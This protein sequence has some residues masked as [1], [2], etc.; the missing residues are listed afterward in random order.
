MFVIFSA[1]P[2]RNATQKAVAVVATAVVAWRAVP[3]KR[4]AWI[5][6]GLRRW[7]LQRGWPDGWRLTRSIRGRVVRA[8]VIKIEKVESGDRRQ[9]RVRD[10][11]SRM[12]CPGNFA[13]P[14]SPTYIFITSDRI[15]FRD[16]KIYVEYPRLFF[17]NL[18]PTSNSF[19][20][21]IYLVFQFNRSSSPSASREFMRQNQ[22][23]LES[24]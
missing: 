11:T 24:G 22:K 23:S 16:R 12:S 18:C 19:Y 15:A 21:V 5:C 6:V 9:S 10:F 2:L 1:R 17:G 3:G 7:Q 20:L 14:S 8:T 4:A 13:P